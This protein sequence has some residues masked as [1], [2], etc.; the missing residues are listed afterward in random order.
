MEV[1]ENPFGK[2]DHQDIDMLTKAINDDFLVKSGKQDRVA[3]AI[4]DEVF[5]KYNELLSYC[6]NNK[7]EL[8]KTHKFTEN[9]D[10]KG[11]VLCL[12]DL[13]LRFIKEVSTDFKTMNYKKDNM[14]KLEGNEPIPEPKVGELIYVPGAAYV[15]RGSE[16]FAGGIA[17]ISKVEKSTHLS[18]DHYNYIMIG[19]DSRPNTMYNY[20][21]L[22][23]EQEELKKEYRDRV[24]HPDP[25]HRPE[26][27]QPD[28][29]W[30]QA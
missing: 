8:I 2:L 26:F 17:V 6:V 25:D 9:M 5:K 24:A 13:R 29:D 30:K 23:E 16:D 1:M 10:Y 7:E 4:R 19:I 28:A 20:R 27:N 11:W 14:S 3:M 15:Y 12:L 18:P 22:L 21:S